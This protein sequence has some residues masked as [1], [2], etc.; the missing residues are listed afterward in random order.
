MKQSLRVKVETLKI[1]DRHESGSEDRRGFSLAPGGS[2]G[3]D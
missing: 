2:A 1:Y 3:Y